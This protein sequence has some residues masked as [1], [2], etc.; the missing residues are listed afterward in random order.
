MIVERINIQSE[1]YESDS[2]FNFDFLKDE[3]YENR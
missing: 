3:Y 2:E 1:I